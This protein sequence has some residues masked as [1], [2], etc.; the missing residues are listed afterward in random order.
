MDTPALKSDATKLQ[1]LREQKEC[2]V[3][4]AEIARL[5]RDLSI[6]AKQAQWV[7]ESISSTGC[8]F[9]F[10]D[11]HDDIPGFGGYGRGVCGPGYLNT[12]RDSRR[13]G[14]NRPIFETEEDLAA[15]RMMARLLV[16]TNATAIGIE[17]TLTNYTIGQGFKISVEP[18]TQFAKDPQIEA[19]AKEA[20]MALDEFDE[21][22]QWSGDLDREL[23]R[24]S[25]RDGEFFSM[26]GQKNGKV[27]ARQIEPE[28]V[29]DPMCGMH[30]D[31]VDWKF[32]VGTDPIDIQDVLGF[33]VRW[34]SQDPTS[35]TLF[36]PLNVVHHKR[37]VDRTVKRGLPDYFAVDS[38]LHDTA[39]LN[40]NITRGATVQA[41]IAYIKEH[42][43]EMQKSDI[44]AVASAAADYSYQYH[45]GTGTTKTV[46]S[47]DMGSGSILDV[48]GGTKYVAGPGGQ[49]QN[50]FIASFQAGLR[51]IG[52]RWCFPEFMVSGDASNANFASTVVAES[53]FVQ[54]VLAEQHAFAGASRRVM[55]LVLLR[56]WEMGG[57]AGVR[58]FDD[59]RKHL[60]IQIET[61]DPSDRDSVDK[62]TIRE[63]Q[64]RAGI[65]S[66]RSRAA[67]SK[68]DFDIEQDN[69]AEEG[70]PA[71]FDTELAPAEEAALGQMESLYEDAAKLLEGRRGC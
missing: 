11:P 4:Q 22:N 35:D 38:E 41:A 16:N 7:P 34:D 60:T 47:R 20:Q 62:E 44:Q 59:L 57:F 2:L 21:V 54:N 1:A 17:K 65:L 23:F 45:T 53:P 33:N 49:R 36:T 51:N 28:L 66:K 63:M 71:S 40:R 6:A 15:F 67:K 9:A 50:T 13:D 55:W 5:E 68:L 56:H 30:G 32:G 52:V 19:F 69:I 61:P 8:N 29:T 48:G 18:K 12:D 27:V 42:P 46:L 26:I 14:I 58:N 37:N 43:P 64:Q 25:V 3:E 24:R 39:K 31:T 10:S 70:G